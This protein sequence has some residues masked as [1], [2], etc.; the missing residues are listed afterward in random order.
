MLKNYFNIALRNLIRNKGFSIINIS[1]LAIGMASALLILLWIGQELSYDDFHQNKDYIYQAWN[2][3]VMDG[4]VECWPNTPKI[5]GPTLKEEYPEVA[6]TARTFDQWLVSIVGDKKLTSQFLVADPSFLKMFSFPLTQG[7][8]NQALPDGY[9]I[10]ITE[11]MARKMFASEDVLGK[12]LRLNNDVYKV[13]GVLKDLPI[14]SRFNFEGIISWEFVKR[15]GDDDTN[16][17]NNGIFTFVQLKPGQSHAEINERI[18]RISQTHSHGI[19]KEEIFLHPLKSWHLYS[20]FHNRKTPG[21]RIETVRLFGIIGVF[22]LLIACINFMNLSTARSEKRAK[23]VGIRKVAGALRS[24]I[25][26]QFLGESILL[27]FIA[28]L[29]ALMLIQLAL[30]YFNLLIDGQLVLPIDNLYIWTVF[31]LFVLFTG[32]LAGSYP[33][34]FLSA[35]KP[36][37]VLKGTFRQAFS[38]INPRR[39]LVVVQFT[40]T[41]ILL[42]STFVV[43]QQI[44]YAQNR[45][46]GYDGEQIVY[47]WLTGDL[48]KNYVSL[49]HDL[50]QSGLATSVTKTMSPLTTIFSDTWDLQW[51]GKTEGDK[52]DF[53]RLSEDEDLVRTAGLE[54]VKGRDMD[55]QKYPSDSTAMLAN[56]SAI[57]AMGFKDPIGQIVKETDGTSYHIIGVVKDFIIGSPYNHTKPLVIEGVTGSGFNVINIRITEDK[58]PSEKIDE[59]RTLFQKYNPEYPFE[60]H[61]VSDEY[62]R[63]FEDTKQ[64]A[65]LTM[66]FAILTVFISCLGLFG[67]ASYMAEVRIKEIGIRKVLGASVMRITML[68]SKDFV[69]LVVISIVLAIPIAWYAMDSWLKR[70]AYR[71]DLNGWVFAAAGILCI[72][73]ALLTVSYQ[74]I[75]AALENPVRSLRNE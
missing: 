56:E 75:R 57:K 16:W 74:S 5:L 45:H 58:D 25:I 24:S 7:N 36:V 37:V 63:K 54:L 28:S 6:E 9:S 40:F 31:A 70:F 3:G 11:K 61:F 12:E 51:Q 53:E 64:T 30:P 4:N 65:N 48:E 47:H 71:V 55:L 38:S 72:L 19:V 8:I 29:L 69:T 73:I 17:S 42:I 59:L 44:R 21:G 35:F 52:T 15:K 49:K 22:I 68:L 34:F 41:V 26:S 2:R 43:L 18:R 39:V 1:G 33:A 23:E 32:F 10:V 20:D 14:N 46:R 13:T 66:V 62:A 50:L 27:T 60:Y 67:L